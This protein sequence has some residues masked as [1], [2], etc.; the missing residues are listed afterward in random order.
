MC[1]NDVGDVL[2]IDHRRQDV[3]ATGTLPLVVEG[4][5]AADVG[6]VAANRASQLIDAAVLRGYCLRPCAIVVSEDLERIAQ[7]GLDHVGDTQ[8]FPCGVRQ[9]HRRRIKR[10]DIEMDGT[11]GIGRCRR[12]RQPAREEPCERTDGSQEHRGER[13]I[14]CQVKVDDQAPGRGFYLL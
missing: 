11:A 12:V 3:L 10:R 4:L 9:R 7:H 2:E 5:L 6:E 14:E 13:E 8:G 1:S